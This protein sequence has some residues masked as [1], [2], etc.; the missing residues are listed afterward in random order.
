M[1]F[2]NSSII[3]EMMLADKPVVTYKNTCPGPYLIDC[4]DIDEIGDALERAISRPDNLIQAMRNY[5]AQFEAHRDGHNSER[6]L[7]AVDDFIL[8][9]KHKLRSKPLN[10]FRKIKLRW[11]VKNKYF[12]YLFLRK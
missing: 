12:K 2:D 11:R 6:V 7:A 9:Q 1:L 4:T 3:I 8:N 5:V 10:L